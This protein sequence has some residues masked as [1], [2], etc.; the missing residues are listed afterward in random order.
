MMALKILPTCGEGNREAV[1]G[2]VRRHLFRTPPSVSPSACHL[3][4]NGED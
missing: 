4:M 1:E 2:G 3:P